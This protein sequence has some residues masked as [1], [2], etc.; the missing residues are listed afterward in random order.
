MKKSTQPVSKLLSR[1]AA[2]LKSM[3][4][5]KNQLQILPSHI[6]RQIPPLT[7]KRKASVLV[8]LID[9]GVQT[10]TTSTNDHLDRLSILFTKRAKNLKEHA[11]EI[12]FPG[13]HYEPE[14]DGDSLIKTAIRE[15][16]EELMNEEDCNNVND[17]NNTNSKYHDFK[18][19]LVVIGQA[20]TIP[21]A[22]LIPITPFFAY[23]KHEISNAEEL[24]P[25]NQN[26]VSQVFT[27]S[28]RELLQ[29]EK[30]MN[31]DRLSMEG[32]V[33]PTKYGDIWGL[34]ALILKPFLHEVLKPTFSSHEGECNGKNK[35][36]QNQ[37]FL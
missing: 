16:C 27:V 3:F 25:G 20:E 6:A 29:I 26:E 30:T 18:E 2:Q 36:N 13:G 28:V 24:F 35:K 1:N 19:K 8:P 32:P 34:T 4:S 17:D 10:A 21:S 22:K 11:N 5:S 12:S 7:T 9:S 15:T 14:V 37:S 33:Y 31:L 23:F